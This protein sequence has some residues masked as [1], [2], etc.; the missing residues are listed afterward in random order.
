[1]TNIPEVKR[2]LQCS[3]ERHLWHSGLE[4]AIY[5]KLLHLT[6]IKEAK[7]YGVYH[8]SKEAMTDFLGC[9]YKSGA[10]AFLS[11]VDKGWLAQ[12][13]E[14]KSKYKSKNYRIVPHNEW[15]ELN[16]GNCLV[17]EV[18]P[19]DSES[20]DRDPLAT[21]LYKASN[22]KFRFWRNQLSALRSSHLTDDAIVKACVD[23]MND[24]QTL[25]T[26]SKAWEKLRW[27][28]VKQMQA[29]SSAAPI[30]ATK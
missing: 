1:M 26:N 11:L 3:A 22:G 12:V 8:T 28:F 29:L 6:W 2:G 27:K 23:L 30:G 19:W 7:Q 18:M 17:G 5:M 15:A 13:G 20:S 16:P 21:R 24:E 14:S 4:L 10:A 25:P 9:Y